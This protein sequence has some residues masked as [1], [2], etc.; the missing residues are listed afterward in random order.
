MS[1]QQEQSLT[2]IDP[3]NGGAVRKAI[4]RLAGPSLAENILINITQMLS[5]IMVSR[6]GGEAVAAVGVTTQPFLLLLALFMA[7]NIGTTVIVARSIGAGKLDEANRASGQ[8]FLLNILCSIVIVWLSCT[9]ADHLLRLMGANEQLVA[10]GER[11]AELIFFSI[12][13]TTLSMSLTA[14][15][16]GAGD[17]RTPMKINVLANVLVVVIGFPLIYGLFGLPKLGLTGA[18]VATII[19]QIVSML[20]VVSIMFS[21]KYAIRLQ[22]KNVLTFD[23]QMIARIWKI[24]FPSSVEQIIMRLGMLTFVTVSASLGTAALASTQI[25]FNIMGITFMPG[26]AFAIAAT[27]LVGQALGASKPEL[28]ERYGWQVRKFGMWITGGLGVGLFL[29]APYIMLL[30]TNDPEITSYGV[31]ALRIMGL[32][33]TSQATQFILSGALR[34][35]GDTRFPLVTAL[36]SVWGVRVGL[37]F[38]FVYGFRLGVAGLW[39]AAASD[40]FTR[41]ILI[42]QRYKRG[43]WKLMKV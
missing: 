39:I 40:Q 7:L 27:T 13:F 16:R 12:G 30:Y 37:C 32:I 6:V 5:M 20:W 3:E 21:G 29:F 33:Q 41:S 4:F 14:I 31:I 2:L 11:Y 15:L 36:I 43:K 18:A 19:S 1:K 34:G 25:A 28:A 8:A 24:G 38:L 42:F 23:R 35:A 26:M 9:N 17:T 10:V 22:W